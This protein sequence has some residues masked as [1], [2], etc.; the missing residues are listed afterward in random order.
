MLGTERAHKGI[1]AREQ[2]EPG[3]N[4]L[5]VVPFACYVV[6]DFRVSRRAEQN[7]EGVLRGET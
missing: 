5:E 6:P 3:F 4:L 7:P 1:R 2:K